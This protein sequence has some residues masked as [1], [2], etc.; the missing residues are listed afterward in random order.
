LGR[1][2]LDFHEAYPQEG[3][4]RFADSAIQYIEKNI[5]TRPIYFSERPSQLATGYKITRTGFNLFR[6][7]KK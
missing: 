7:D 2:N 6:I 1:A 4:D 3:V 5:D